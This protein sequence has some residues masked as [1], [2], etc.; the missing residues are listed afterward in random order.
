MFVA[1]DRRK[2]DVPR[3]SKHLSSNVRTAGV[4][5]KIFSEQLFAPVWSGEA[6]LDRYLR[7]GEIPRILG[8]I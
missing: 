7:N 5:A 1:N 6:C 3:P 2:A 4:V 8:I